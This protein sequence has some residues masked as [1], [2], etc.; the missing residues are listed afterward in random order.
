MGDSHV[1]SIDSLMDLYTY[2]DVGLD[3]DENEN[4]KRRF[5]LGVSTSQPEDLHSISIDLQL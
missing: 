1:F 3:V 2:I 4:E 5:V